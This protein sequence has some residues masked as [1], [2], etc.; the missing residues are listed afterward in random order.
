MSGV[1]PWGELMIQAR[2]IAVRAE[3]VCSE[4]LPQFGIREVGRIF[5]GFGEA[6]IVWVVLEGHPDFPLVA[7]GAQPFKVNGF[8]FGPTW[9]RD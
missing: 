1:Q 4:L 2:Q 5:D 9:K 6:Q 3:E 8:R 7:D